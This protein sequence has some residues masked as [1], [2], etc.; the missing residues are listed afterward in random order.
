MARQ[1]IKNSSKTKAT[2]TA[3][4]TSTVFTFAIEFSMNVA[5]RNW[6][7]LAM[8][9]SGIVRWIFASSTSIARVNE[10]VSA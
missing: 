5:C 1:F 7:R 9:P 3:A 6:T 2:T 10:T 8:T 4:S